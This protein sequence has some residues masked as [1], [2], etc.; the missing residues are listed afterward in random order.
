[1]LSLRNRREGESTGDTAVEPGKSMRTK[2]L[3][4]AFGFVIMFAVLWWVF[5]RVMAD[6]N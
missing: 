1:M 3:Q 4:G 5:S 2:V 6:E